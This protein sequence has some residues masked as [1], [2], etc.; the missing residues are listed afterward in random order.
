MVLVLVMQDIFL[1]E[2]NQVCTA[3]I[4]DHCIK[5]AVNMYCMHNARMKGA[6]SCISILAPTYA[7][8]LHERTTFQLIQQPGMM[9]LQHW[10]TSL[11]Q[12]LMH[13]LLRLMPS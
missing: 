5:Q 1:K 13:Q 6:S 4:T 7:G 8:C 9:L 11:M 2:N 10:W 3:G 12:T